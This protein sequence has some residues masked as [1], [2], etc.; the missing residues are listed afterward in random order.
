[1]PGAMWRPRICCGIQSAERT[2]MS[3]RP[4]SS[5][6]AR[7]EVGPAQ[8]VPDPF[9]IIGVGRSGTSIIA[10]VLNQ[11]SLVHVMDESHLWASLG[12]RASADLTVGDFIQALERVQLT[13]GVHPDGHL[14]RLF[15]M[16]EQRVR[17]IVGAASPDQT[18]PLR[19]ILD[20][21]MGALAHSRGASRWGE[22]TPAHLDHVETILAAYPSAKFIYMLRDGRDVAVSLKRDNWGP[23]TL[24]DAAYKWQKAARRG[25][26]LGAKLGEGRWLTMS[27]EALVAR[28]DE[29]VRRV[30]EFLG[31]AFET[32]MLSPTSIDTG[33]SIG[34]SSRGRTAQNFSTSFLE[35]SKSPQSVFFAS[36]VGNWRQLSREDVES[37]EA[38]MGAELLANG[39]ELTT[40]A[41]ERASCSARLA[42]TS[43]ANLER[44]WQQ[45][46]DDHQRR[47]ETLERSMAEVRSQLEGM[48]KSL[49]E[50]LTIIR[51]LSAK[52][53]GVIAQLST[54]S[55]KHDD[56]V[57]QLERIRQGLQRELNRLERRQATGFESLER[58]LL[59]QGIQPTNSRKYGDL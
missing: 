32:A 36:S 19:R 29:Q 58:A 8:T 59:G 50:R 7:E 21:L 46:F 45:R 24:H 13:A 53:A 56:Q 38:L 37:L 30:T 5:S 27:Y 26:E 40:T 33:S 9:F 43:V 15:G 16:N 48:Q 54:M 20:P 2:R 49:G 11:H 22:K 3:P 25:R 52:Q 34:F 14:A 17:E 51:E 55:G 18:L 42:V 39:Y 44:S 6:F 41:D 12:A 31:L 57:A 28:P 1:M 35:W 4:E 23:K 10:E 47:T